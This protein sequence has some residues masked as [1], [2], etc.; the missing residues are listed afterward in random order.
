MLVSATTPADAE[1]LVEGGHILLTP[2]SQCTTPTGHQPQTNKQNRQM[3][4]FLSYAS[5]LSRRNP[6]THDQERAQ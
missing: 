5:S 6:H 1:L 4:R 3:K 2:L